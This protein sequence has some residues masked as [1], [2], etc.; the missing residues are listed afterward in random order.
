M[1]P[2]VTKESLYRQ[3]A[4]LQELFPGEAFTLDGAYGGWRLE[5]ISKKGRISHPVGPEFVSKRQLWEKV[6]CF[7]SGLEF[8][9]Y[10]RHQP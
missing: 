3:I 2:K 1:K 10:L 9:A 6:D 5:H 8:S 4:R 7:R